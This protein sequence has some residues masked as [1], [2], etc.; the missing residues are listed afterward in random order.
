MSHKK[1][2][3]LERF[4]DR[5]SPEP[6]SGCW[7]WTGAMITLGYGTFSPS[8][9]RGEYTY[10]HRYSYET[11]VG[12]IPDGMVIDHLCRVRCC[13]NPKHLEVV[14]RGE[15]VRRGDAPAHV[16]RRNGTCERGHELTP[17]NL[18]GRVKPRCWVCH[19]EWK[20]QRAVGKL[21]QRMVERARA[22]AALVQ[23]N[24]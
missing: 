23:P 12:P 13:V 20:E 3:A 14:T 21:L 6:N 2:P 19:Q 17:G 22:S 16:A 9:K 24:Q 1:K 4:M 10:S 8:Q 15:N 11:F 7:L 18:V 5:V